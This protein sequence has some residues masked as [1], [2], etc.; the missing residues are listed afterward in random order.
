MRLSIIRLAVED[1]LKKSLGAP[2]LSIVGIAGK[3]PVIDEKRQP[4]IRV[5]YGPSGPDEWHGVVPATVDFRRSPDAA[6]ERLRLAVKV[7]PAQ[8]LART[9]NSWIIREHGIALDRPYPEYHAASEFDHTGAREYHVFNGLAPGCPSLARV[10]P[11]CYGGVVDGKSGEHAIFLEFLDNVARLDAAGAEGDWPPA[12]IASA[13]SAAGGWHGAF[14]GKVD[15]MD[16][17]FAAPRATTAQRLADEGLWRGLLD[18]ARGRFPDILTEAVWR[19]RH[20]IVDT[21]D[22]WHPIKDQLPVTLVHDDFNNRN[23]GFRP[24]PIAL[25]WE[26]AA[27]D[28]PQ[29]DLVELLTFVL[30]AGT[31]RSEVKSLVDGH[32]K[33]IIESAGDLASGLDPEGFEQA[34]RAELKLQAINRI[35]HQFL[36]AAAFPLPYL[37]RI[38][39]CIEHLL[40]LYD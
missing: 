26:L 38:N 13:L 23:C 6:V 30:P 16:D 14:L 4:W 12:L 2:G 3:R 27:R 40:D 9:L 22:V 25:D 39:A 18:N 34:F 20:H 11:R 35:G 19:R 28:A 24:A 21:I 8:G 15:H 17:A 1:C 29:R 31:P 37:A 33:A 10:L 32:R 7:N 36:F 5:K